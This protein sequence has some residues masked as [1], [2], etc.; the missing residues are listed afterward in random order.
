MDARYQTYNPFRR[1]AWRAERAL[2]LAENQPAPLPAR[3]YDDHYVRA[4]R[5][6]VLGVL[7]A[8]GEQTQLETIYREL[9][10]VHRAHQ[11]YFDSN[12]TGRQNLEAWLLTRKSTSDIATRLSAEVKAVEYFEQLFFSVRDR[13]DCTDWI[14]KVINGWPNNLISHPDARREFERGVLYRKFAY[15]G[16]P[17]VLDALISG[18]LLGQF[19]GCA[20]DIASFFAQTLTTSIRLQSIARAIAGDTPFV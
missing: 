3:R 2:Q 11:I 8:D 9:P 10:D 5:H 16:G 15:Y 6:Y 19:P 17:H 12:Y 4:Y 1:P 7:A 14:N 18:R 13:M 20:E